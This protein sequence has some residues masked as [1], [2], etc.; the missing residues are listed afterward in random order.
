M[1]FSSD[2]STVNPTLL[3]LHDLTHDLALETRTV[4]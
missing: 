4:L 1:I 3:L 2:V